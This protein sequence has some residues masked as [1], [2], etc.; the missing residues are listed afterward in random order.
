MEASEDDLLL[1]S[2]LI[3]DQQPSDTLQIILHKTSDQNRSHYLNGTKDFAYR[4]DYLEKR[5]DHERSR[6]RRNNAPVSSSAQNGSDIDNH[7]RR[8]DHSAHKLDDNAHN[9]DYRARVSD[10]RYN[11]YA[12]GSHHHARRSDHLPDKDNRLAPEPNHRVREYRDHSAEREKN[13]AR[14]SNHPAR[15]SHLHARGANYHVRR[16]VRSER[17]RNREQ[18]PA[19]LKSDKPDFRSHFENKGGGDN[20]PTI[21]LRNNI[22]REYD[23]VNRGSDNSTAESD[24]STRGS[25]YD[26]YGSDHSARDRKRNREKRPAMRHGAVRIRNRQVRKYLVFTFYHF[27][28]VLWMFKNII[29]RCNWNL[30][31][32]LESNHFMI[33][34]YCN[35]NTRQITK[36]STGFGD[37]CP[38]NTSNLAIL[39][40]ES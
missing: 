5:S 19:D 37:F 35:Y 31:S 1:S 24:N 28:K 21:Q 6:G 40:I 8:F 22:K 17:R 39:S 34:I 29:S 25:D 36:R 27:L 9:S 26:S 38:R 20:S 11:D 7:A 33:K 4:S 13:L 2:N 14:G 3:S 18:E 12:R 32:N 16:S 30:E 15:G 10:R 23:K